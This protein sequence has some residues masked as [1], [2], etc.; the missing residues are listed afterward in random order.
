MADFIGPD[1]AR[2]AIEGDVHLGGSLAVAQLADGRTML[3]ADG[4]G[5][6]SAPAGSLVVGEAAAGAVGVDTLVLP[7]ATVTVS[8][9]VATV[10]QID[11]ASLE[12]GDSAY[13]LA[14]AHHSG[15]QLA[16]T[17]SD[18]TETVQDLVGALVA[19]GANITATYNDGAGTLTLAVTGTL[20]LAVGGTGADGSALAAGRVLASPAVGSGAAAYR[21]LAAADIPSL[22]AAA[23]A[24]GQL[25]TARGGTG[26]DGS[27]QAAGKVFAA[28]AA[29]TGAATFRALADTD[30]PSL[31]ASRIGT[32]Q[33]ATARGGTGADGSSVAA[34]RVLASP[35]AATGALALR[36]L[37]A[38]D[39]PTVPASRVDFIDAVIDMGAGSNV[40]IADLT[41]T[42]TLG[43]AE[44]Q[45]DGPSTLNDTVNVNGDL[46]T[47]GTASAGVVSGPQRQPHGAKSAAYTLTTSDA[48][49]DV[50]A[51][52]AAR[53]I[54][55]P[56]AVT[57]GSGRTYRITKVDAS[58]NAVTITPA[59]G[60]T[61]NGAATKALTAQWQSA[62]LY[63]NGTVWRAV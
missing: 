23:I 11:A 35:A 21:A 8:G 49:V 53:V 55:L 52:G 37:V 9:T 41:V 40:S 27:S 17:I 33:L 19:S 48:I 24:S 32:G 20:P 18:L 16:A 7:S 6:G 54:T 59:A 62:L 46:A 58:A 5:G 45:V 39:I 4:G 56:S 2:I 60:Q 51:T 1:G 50:D 29:S 57:V 10:D 61:I 31:P 26:A 25:T 15:T 30:V 3:T 28:P 44:L 38:S 42:G 22:D 47:S 63:S 34:G 12:G 36:A 14:R 13:H 43:L